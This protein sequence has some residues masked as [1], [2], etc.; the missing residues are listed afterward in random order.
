MTKLVVEKMTDMNIEH[1]HTILYAY[2]RTF[3]VIVGHTPF[4]LV[5]ATK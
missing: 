2:R 1:L 3:K 4:Q 5:R